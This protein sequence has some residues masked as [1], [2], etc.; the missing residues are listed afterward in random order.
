MASFG[1]PQTS[2]YF[3]DDDVDPL[4]PTPVPTKSKLT[5]LPSTPP[6]LTVSS[7]IGHNGRLDPLTP[8]PVAHTKMEPPAGST[9]GPIITLSSH[10]NEYDDY[11]NLDPLAS[12]HWGVMDESSHTVL[13]KAQAPAPTQPVV[14]TSSDYDDLD[15]LVSASVVGGSSNPVEVQA[16]V[17]TQSVITMSS[18]Y[19]DYDDLDPLSPIPAPQ[20]SNTSVSSIPPQQTI[21][22]S[23]NYDDIDPLSPDPVTSQKGS[24][25][26]IVTLIPDY[27]E[28]DPLAPNPAALQQTISHVPP[29]PTVAST[30]DYE[31]LD[32]LS[33]AP[34]AP[35]DLSL[36]PTIPTVTSGG[37]DNDDLD[38]LAPDPAAHKESSPQQTIT[39]SLGYDEQDP[40]EPVKTRNTLAID[41]HPPIAIYIEDSRDDVNPWSKTASGTPETYL[42]DNSKSNDALAVHS[43]PGKRSMVA[44]KNVQG[45]RTL[46]RYPHNLHPVCYLIT[47]H[48]AYHQA[49]LWH[50]QI[51]LTSRRPLEQDYS[52][53]YD[54]QMKGQWSQ[55]KFIEHREWKKIGKA[56]LQKLETE[57]FEQEDKIKD[58]RNSSVR[59]EKYTRLLKERN[60]RDWKRNYDLMLN[61]P[62]GVAGNALGVLRVII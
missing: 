30:L 12:P 7:R 28:L 59:G 35:K 15:P 49:T 38:P 47:L 53:K 31:E 51:H 46:I 20:A 19:D 62:G 58:I 9:P 36:K 52:G 5:E 39:L 6:L 26:A 32:P 4:A 8:A 27:D 34:V 14:T 48:E 13:V 21:S 22:S 45:K 18:N 42:S 24:P 11:D 17:A 2:V 44:P 37:Y 3:E 54:N 61:G 1:V 16:P 55:L 41:I 40:L 25:Q 43:L 50:T 33:P 57:V 60:E 23:Q 56:H 10:H 29:Q